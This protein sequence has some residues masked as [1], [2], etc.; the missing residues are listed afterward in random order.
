MA[1]IH[2]FADESG[3]FDFSR[4]RDATR[5]FIL[6]TVSF[7]DDKAACRDLEELRYDLAWR[8]IDHP[9]PFH[10][11]EDQQTVRDE[12]Y[13]TLASHDFRVDALIVEKSKAQ[14]QIRSSEAM[15]YQYVWWLHM[16]HVAPQLAGAWDELL[17][18]AASIGG[19]KAKRNAFH[20]A[21]RRVMRQVT[22]TLRMGTA[23][24]R[25]DSDTGLQIADYCAWAL[26]RKWEDADF[27]SYALIQNKLHSEFDV[28]ARGAR[29]YY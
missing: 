6:A 20:T 12:V 2:V 17:V 26:K 7:F 15:F 10:A 5:Y 16:K 19:K 22:P 23:A 24:W 11:T 3:N 14:P 21:V 28:F 29:H 1:R 9:G 4:K 25:A 18:I 27:R 13:Q 8:G